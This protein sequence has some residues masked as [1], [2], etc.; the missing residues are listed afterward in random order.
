MRSSRGIV[1]KRRSQNRNYILTLSLECIAGYYLVSVLAYLL[2]FVMNC[3]LQYQLWFALQQRWTP[4]GS[5]LPV[6]LYNR[7]LIGNNQHLAVKHRSLLS[8]ADLQKSCEVRWCVVHIVTVLPIPWR[9]SYGGNYDPCCYNYMFSGHSWLS[10][11]FALRWPTA[12]YEE[13]ARTHWLVQHI[14]WQHG[15]PVGAAGAC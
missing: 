4:S 10:H 8:T 11:V 1:S 6:R 7:L 14:D 12:G 15:Q 9:C 2:C 13:V 3:K 5:K